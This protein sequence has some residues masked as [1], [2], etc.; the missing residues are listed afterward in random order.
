MCTFTQLR[1]SKFKFCTISVQKKN[2]LYCY[3]SC[4]SLFSYSY[5]IVTPIICMKT[6]YHKV[7]EVDR[8]LWLKENLTTN[9]SSKNHSCTM[10]Y[11][12]HSVHINWRISLVCAMV[13]SV[14]NVQAFPNWCSVLKESN[15]H[16][17]NII[18][19]INAWL[20]SSI[21]G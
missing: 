2:S 10:V 13:Y 4:I 20:V 7:Q 5:K 1:W 6:K 19:Y 15:D 21:N 9:L 14:V 3:I 16:C 17:I 12:D 18:F 11:A 8:K